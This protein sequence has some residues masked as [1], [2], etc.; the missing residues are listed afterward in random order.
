MQ[1]PKTNFL[2]IYDVFTL[3]VAL[4]FD[5]NAFLKSSK[6]S[7]VIRTLLLGRTFQLRHLPC[8]PQMSHYQISNSSFGAPWISG[9]FTLPNLLRGKPN[10]WLFVQWESEPKGA[11]RVEDLIWE[12][13][14]RVCRN[15]QTRAHISDIPSLA[16]SLPPWYPTPVKSWM[17]SLDVL[18]SNLIFKRW[19][20]ARSKKQ[21]LSLFR[22]FLRLSR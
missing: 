14:L 19:Y 3:E 9:F 6:G 2:R 1:T 21:C 4:S 12:R 11:T 10:L 18:R 22:Y 20:M 17:V 13:I 8:N 15:P 5:D 16:F 7:G